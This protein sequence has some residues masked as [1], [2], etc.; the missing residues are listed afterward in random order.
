MEDEDQGVYQIEYLEP[1][2]D[3]GAPKVTEVVAPDGTSKKVMLPEIR[4]RRL[5][6]V[7]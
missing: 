5:I 2:L 4:R 3:V 7:R 6:K 1:G